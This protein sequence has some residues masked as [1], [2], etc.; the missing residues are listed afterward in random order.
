MRFMSRAMRRPIML[1]LA[2]LYALVIIFLGRPMLG[3]FGPEYRDGYVP[4]LII[5]GGTVVT[6]VKSLSPIYI[7][8]AGREW[9]VPIMLAI[10]VGLTFALTIPLAYF[11]GAI[12][13]AIGYSV[14]GATLFIAFDIYARHLRRKRLHALGRDDLASSV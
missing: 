7:Q 3:L 6:S 11:W 4:L 10:G 5:A 9:T 14:S 1:G 8:Y 2:L 12:G 13:A